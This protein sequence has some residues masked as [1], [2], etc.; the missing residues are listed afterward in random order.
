MTLKSLLVSDDLV[1][2]YDVIVPKCDHSAGASSPDV[3][4]RLTFLYEA[5]RYHESAQVT[6][7]LESVRTGLWQ[8]HPYFPTFAETVIEAYWTSDTGLATVGFN[9]TKLVS[10]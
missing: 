3:I 6:S 10:R 8:D 4:E 1:H 2:L 7:L 5:Y 9:R